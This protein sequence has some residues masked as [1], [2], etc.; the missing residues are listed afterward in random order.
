MHNLSLD[1][2]RDHLSAALFG[3]HFH[4]LPATLVDPLPTSGPSSARH[5]AAAAPTWLPSTSTDPGSSLLARARAADSATSS[6]GSPH[7]PTHDE[8]SHLPARARPRRSSSTGTLLAR[9]SSAAPR[10][11]EEP[12]SSPVAPDPA[13][14]GPSSSRA[15]SASRASVASAGSSSTVRQAPRVPPP[16]PHR[17]SERERDRDRPASAAQFAQRERQRRE[18]ALRRRLVDCFVSL[19]LVPV[20]VTV[21][22]ARE[23]GSAPARDGQEEVPGGRR[24]SGSVASALMQRSGSAG[25]SHGGGPGAGGLSA[26]RRGMRRRMTASSLLSTSASAS[27]PASASAAAA[28]QTPPFFVSPPSR[29]S[30]H[31]TFLINPAHFLLPREADTDTDTDEAAQGGP[32][33]PGDPATASWPGLREGR[34]RARVFGRPSEV[35]LGKGKGRA[36]GDED[37]DGRDGG[38]RLLA[39]WDVELGGLTSLG[40]DVRLLFLSSLSLSARSPPCSTPRGPDPLCRIRSPPCSP[41]CPPTPS[42]LPSRPRPPR[43]APP[44]NPRPRPPPPPLPPPRPTPSTSPRRS[45]SCAGR[46]AHPRPAARGRAR[47]LLSRGRAR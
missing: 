41:P 47:A 39:E 23:G 1:P 24:R 10:I 11:D 20:P 26:P 17:P 30:T 33:L 13:D 32:A 28:A 42:S 15:R 34:V 37:E 14:A 31:A 44:P 29:A 16:A 40:R 43:S 4:S 8:P 21:P 36:R 45:R 35:L 18:E 19:E 7:R 25:S 3:G 27:L 6:H 9:P 5:P 12:A 2:R 46:R 38:W 22:V